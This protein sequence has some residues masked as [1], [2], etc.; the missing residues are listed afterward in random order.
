MVSALR[1]T[2]K[3]GACGVSQRTLLSLGDKGIKL[4]KTKTLACCQP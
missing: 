4:L 2:A 3:H 1:P